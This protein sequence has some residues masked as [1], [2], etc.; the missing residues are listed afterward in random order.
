MSPSFIQKFNTTRINH[1]G[2]NGDISTWFTGDEDRLWYDHDTNTIRVGTG[3]ALTRLLFVSANSTAPTGTV[4][5]GSVDYISA[6]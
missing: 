6:T 2:S 1:D 5:T 3:L 4:I